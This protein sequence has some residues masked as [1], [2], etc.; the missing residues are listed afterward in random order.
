MSRESLF[1]TK[2]K[3]CE[4]CGRPLPIDYPND[5]CPGCVENKLFREV[6]EFIRANDVNEY[7]V[8]AAFNIPVR[9]VKQWVREGRIEYKENP[10]GQHTIAEIRCHQ[11]GAPV[12]FGTLCPKCLKALNNKIHGYDAQKTST[13]S[14]MRYLDDAP[15][16]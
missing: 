16:P 1:E 11:C 10:S 2:Y 15:L 4:F 6:K 8:A 5:C 13:D 14:R 12:T 7:Q 3:N 9:Q